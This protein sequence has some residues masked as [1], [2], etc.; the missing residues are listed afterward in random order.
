LHAGAGQHT[1]DA[2]IAAFSNQRG[3]SQQQH[4][5]LSNKNVIEACVGQR[6]YAQVGQSLITGETRQTIFLKDTSVTGAGLKDK[7]VVAA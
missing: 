7:Q 5:V 6:P 2:F 1:D 4:I 3:R